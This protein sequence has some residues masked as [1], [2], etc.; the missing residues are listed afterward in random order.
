MTSISSRFHFLALILAI[1]FALGWASI[2]LA[3]SGRRVH[4][5]ASLPA[6][7]PEPPLAPV[8]TDK[9][10]SLRTFIVGVDRYNGFST[11]PLDYYDTVTRA[12]GDRLDDAGSVRV[13]VVRGELTRA[14][15]VARAKAEKEAYVVWLQLKVESIHGDTSIVRNLSQLYIHYAVFA[16]NTAKTVAFGHTYQ[17][18]YRKGGVVVGPPSSGRGSV[19]YS[20]YLLR[21]AARDAAERILDKLKMQVPK[22]PIASRD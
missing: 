6:S 10:K 9:E 13:D 4:K 11:I 18:G 19:V 2:A 8:K 7:T 16:P 12:C 3:Q 15:A 17:R 22:P 20:E 21:E 5:S 14:D 1:T